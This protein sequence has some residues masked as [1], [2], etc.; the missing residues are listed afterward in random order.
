MSPPFAKFLTN[1]LGFQ[2]YNDRFD[3]GAFSKKKGHRHTSRPDYFYPNAEG[4]RGI[5]CPRP[6]HY[7]GRRPLIVRPPILRPPIRVPPPIR[8]PLLD[9]MPRERRLRQRPLRV[10]DRLLER[11]DRRP[12]RDLL[13]RVPFLGHRADHRLRP[14]HDRREHRLTRE[15]DI[16]SQSSSESDYSIDDDGNSIIPRS[17]ERHRPMDYPGFR[18]TPRPGYHPRTH[19]EDYDGLRRGISRVPGL[20]SPDPYRTGRYRDDFDD[21]DDE[22]TED[23]Y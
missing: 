8:P 15:L 4:P 12:Y 10:D 1:L 5:W 21:V 18:H 19:V 3:E 13:P 22:A 23:S 2:V 14:R 9:Y 6:G 11:R 20:A 7:G 16:S 17:Y